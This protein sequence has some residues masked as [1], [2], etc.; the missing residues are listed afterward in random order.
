VPYV[1]V[2]HGQYVLFQ[3]FARDYFLLVGLPFQFLA[4]TWL[5]TLL[6]GLDARLQANPFFRRVASWGPS[7]FGV[8]VAHVAVLMGILALW[9]RFMPSVPAGLEVLVV[10]ALTLLVTYGFVQLCLL[11]PFRLLGVILFGA[12]GATSKTKDAG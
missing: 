4:A 5:L 12:R 2:T 6:Y 1:I 10:A 7:T 8:Y 11:P 3:T 9:D